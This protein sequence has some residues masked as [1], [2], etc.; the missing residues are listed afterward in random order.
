[1]VLEVREV[2]RIAGDALVQRVDLVV[3]HALVVRDVRGEHAD[4]EA[5]RADAL[6]ARGRVLEDVEEL[7]GRALAEVVRERAERPLAVL[8]AVRGR[9][10]DEV[11]QGAV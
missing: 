11:V 7:S 5:D 9:A 10:V 2:P 8:R 3:G 4:A 1:G 6:P